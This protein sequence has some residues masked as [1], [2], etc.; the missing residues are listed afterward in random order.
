[1]KQMILCAAMMSLLVACSGN[2]TAGNNTTPDAGSDMS[3]IDPEA[4]CPQTDEVPTGTCRIACGPCEFGY[5]DDD[6]GGVT[7]TCDGDEW[8]ENDRTAPGPSC[9]ANNGLDMGSDMSQPSDMSSTDMADMSE[10]EDMFMFPDVAA[11]DCFHPSTDPNCP[12]G[13]FGAGTFLRTL[14]IDETE[15]CCRDFTGDGVNDNKIGQYARILGGTGQD[16]N[17]NI[18]TAI[19]AGELSYLF[20]YRDW[21]NEDF[22]GDLGMTVLLGV[23][24]T[25]DFQD[26]LM[27]M[28]TF[29]VTP[30][31]FDDVTGDPKWV[32]D[33]VTVNNGHLVAR[34]GTLNL[35]FPNLLD[36][37]QL[38]A[39]DVRI[40]ADVVPPADL[41]SGGTVALENGELSG[42][43]DRDLF[44]ESMNE[45]SASCACIGLPV[46]EYD[47]DADKYDCVT[48]DEIQTACQF[49][50]SSGCRFLS[51][52][53][54]CQFLELASGDIDVDTDGDGVADA[55]SVGVKFS[56][57]GASVVG[58]Q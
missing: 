26:N 14:E 38:L 4:C 52:R 55:F 39:T 46:F 20:T 40:E 13:E 10:P 2:N 54:A 23:D 3:P 50:P 16:I 12:M 8:V 22:D 34:G 36:Q 51:N 47:A 32:F 25:P 1:M 24:E 58:R 33:D 30:E 19:E 31:S 41:A 56:G 28:G 29:L 37:V 5:R 21:S 17:G 18:A 35:F 15:Q 43:M 9:E 49:D 57:V 6:C 44:Y 7:V 42:A 53:M 11:Q 48:T 27:G 45:A